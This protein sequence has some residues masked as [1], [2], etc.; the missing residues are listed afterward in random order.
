MSDMMNWFNSSF[1]QYEVKAPMPSQC[2]RT[3]CKQLAK[4]HEA[5]LGILPLPQ[6]RVSAKLLSSLC[7]CFIN[8]DMFNLLSSLC[9]CFIN[10][11]VFDLLF[12]LCSCYINIGVF[13]LLFFSLFM[14]HQYWWCVQ[15]V[16]FSLFMLHQY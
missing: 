15:C 8:I 2:F 14:L 7:S 12:F 3:I 9:S 6:L 4:L 10:I 13:D 11:G 16:V 5:L 1:I